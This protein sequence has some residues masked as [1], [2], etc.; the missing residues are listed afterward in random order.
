MYMLYQGYITNYIKR[1][2]DFKQKPQKLYTVVWEL[3]NK[4]PQNSIE[5]NIYYE[6]KIQDNPINILNPITILIHEPEQSKYPFASIT[7]SLNM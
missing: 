3:C 2:R 1:Q 6:E 7:E 5:T 4:N